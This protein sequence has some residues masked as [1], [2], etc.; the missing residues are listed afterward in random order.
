M[1]P[2]AIAE[3][4]A[5]EWLIQE[6]APTNPHRRRFEMWLRLVSLPI[7]CFALQV[8]FSADTAQTMRQRYGPPISETYLMKPGVEASVSFDASGHVCEIVVSPEETAFV[9]RGKTFKRQELIDLV[10]ELVP[11]NERGKPMGG[12]FVNATCMPDN[13]C[14]GTTSDYEKL[15][16]YMNGGNDQERYATIQWTRDECHPRVKN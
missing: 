7:L 1:L 12:G 11:V 2:L 6:A 10:D 9:K 4:E 5:Y 14:A 13:D 3:I 8:S 16:I 15:S